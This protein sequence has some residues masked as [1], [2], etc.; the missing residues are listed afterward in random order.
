MAS[1]VYDR[2]HASYASLYVLATY[3]IVDYTAS[4]VQFHGH[5]RSRIADFESS[6]P[7]K[8]GIVSVGEPNATMKDNVRG[9]H[10]FEARLVAGVL[11]LLI[12]EACHPA[13]KAEKIRIVSRWQGWG[14]EENTLSIVLRGDAYYAGAS[15][16]P[17]QAVRN[18]VAAIMSPPVARP[19]F[20]NLGLTDERLNRIARASLERLEESGIKLDPQEESGFLASFK[21]ERLVRQALNKAVLRRTDDFPK[22]T[23][24]IALANGK[25]I[26]AFSSSQDYLMLPWLI[27]RESG[28]TVSRAQWEVEN[29]GPCDS[30]PPPAG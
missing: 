28:R 11:I 29:G 14:S 21:S 25:R 7:P 3:P 5:S 20:Q 17:Q 19:D 1:Q 2:P 30:T 15:V 13:V 24:D 22:L 27:E 8:M 9:E 4:E 10:A 16:V 6:L 18:L 26:R 23:I 12:S